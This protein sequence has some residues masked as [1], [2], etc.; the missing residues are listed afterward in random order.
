MG[1]PM[2]S[3]L[4]DLQAPDL[5]RDLPGWLVWRFKPNGD[6]KP[7][8]VPFYVS[9][10]ARWGA[11][12]TAADRKR[13][14][15]FDHAKRVA[16]ENG[17]EGVGFAP[18][19]E[20]GISALDFDDCVADGVIDPVVES[21]TAGTYTEF[22]PS[23]NGIRAFVVGSLGT[24][25]SNPKDKSTFGFEVFDCNGF[26]TFT[27]NVTPT[28]ELVGAENYFAPISPELKAFRDSRLNRAREPFEYEGTGETT[29][30]LSDLEI[31]Q[32]LNALPT[33]LSYDE[34][35]NTGMAIH[36]ETQG[37]GFA[38]WDEWSLSNPKGT[39]TE[40][41]LERWAS[42]GRNGGAPYTA[43]S[44]LRYARDEL[45][46][47]TGIDIDTAHPD[48]FP[49]YDVNPK[50]K[51][52]IISDAEFMA[53]QAKL[54]WI[55]KGFLPK[56]TLGVLFGES[57]AGKSFA[58][59]DLCA[60]VSL[61]LST[62]NG[63]RV[64]KGRVLYVVAEGKHGFRQRLKA[65]CFQHGIGATGIDLIEEVTPNLMDA[66]QI[67]DLIKDIRQRDPYDLI[68]M[69]TFA[70]VMPG[71]NENS[72]EDVGL[73]LAQC[74]RINKH[75]GAMV[76]LVHHSGKDS[77]KGARGWSGLRAA[78]DVE[79]EV[80]RFEDARSVTVTKMK[81]GNDN[82]SYGFKL[83]T[84]VL[85]EDEDGD[86][87]TSCI[88]EFNGKAVGS[89]KAKMTEREKLTWHTLHELI[90][91]EEG[92][93]AKVDR[94]LLVETAACEIPVELVARKDNRERAIK[95]AITALIAKGYIEE[96][97]N[98]VC[99]RAENAD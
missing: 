23:G 92:G 25:K 45:H 74:K 73:A 80:N 24:G 68:V 2:Q 84:V 94:D 8:K 93:G 22:S 10:A 82:A 15:T 16:L 27:G 85:G 7:R 11:Q 3:N 35:V 96:H 78:C 62:W 97:E 43:R 42:F 47:E 87:I 50:G 13:L 30:G 38:L 59:L 89:R 14:T 34:W 39:T 65:Y 18:M 56:A 31:H 19:P 6:K 71:A 79:L 98:T 46:V 91:L 55:V 26:V 37:E 99:V 49:T 90:G 72:G 66:A 88:V 75:T 12:G 60:A 67:T 54:E 64:T 52:G 36:H 83:H 4:R 5:L 9:G 86:D 53:Q 20:F 33:D 76:L 63:H 21:L 51:F 70:Q 69:D 57:G 29:L 61:G 95:R 40:Y 1:R 41:N 48:E 28:T 58:C 32:I 44:L 77:S 81:D 17:Y